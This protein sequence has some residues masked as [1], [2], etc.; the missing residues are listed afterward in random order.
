M[1]L[2]S[3]PIAPDDKILAMGLKPSFSACFEPMISAAA[4]IDTDTCRNYAFH[5]RV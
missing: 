4:V 3:A 5:L 1:M 2:G